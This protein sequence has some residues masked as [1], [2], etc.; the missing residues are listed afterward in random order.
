MATRLAGIDTDALM[1]DFQAGGWKWF[2][3]GVAA[4]WILGKIL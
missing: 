2:V 4:T 3:G 1:S